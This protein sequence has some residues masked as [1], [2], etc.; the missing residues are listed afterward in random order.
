MIQ[1]AIYERQNRIPEVTIPEVTSIVGLGGTGFWTATFLAMSGVKELVLL[2]SDTLET[3]NLNRLPVAARAVG[4]KK[5]RVVSEFI[6]TIR[7]PVRIELHEARIEKPEDCTLLR[8]TVFCCT[9]NLKSQQI[10]CAYCKKNKI[11]YQR[12]GY[13]GT[14]LNVSKAFPLSFEKATDEGGYSVT[15]SWVVPAVLA[16]AAGVSSKLYKELCIMDDIGKLHTQGSSYVCPKLLEEATEEAK[17]EARDGILDNIHEY[18]PD[19]Y[20]YCSDCELRYSDDDIQAIKDEAREEGLNEGF[21]EAIAQI[22]AGDIKNSRLKSAV[23]AWEKAKE[24]K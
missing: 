17:E 15:P 10:I 9:D 20:G 1:E 21:E 16:A 5:V 11:P 13:D 3:S 2:D 23:R 18:I 22:K 19:D 24:E 6:K 14:T 7:N 4:M 8:G 12:I